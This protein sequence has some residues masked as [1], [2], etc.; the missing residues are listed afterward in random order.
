MLKRIREF[1]D[2]KYSI[3]PEMKKMM[4]EAACLE[5]EIA[6]Q[7]RKLDNLTEWHQKE[8]AKFETKKNKMHITAESKKDSSAHIIATL[9]VSSH[10]SK[11]EADTDIPKPSVVDE[12]TVSISAFSPPVLEAQK[13]VKHAIQSNETQSREVE[14]RFSELDEAQDQL[15]FDQ[16]NLLNQLNIENKNKSAG[17]SNEMVKK[18]S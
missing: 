9:A 18:I 4:E 15:L 1:F 8:R 3:D 12:T 7:N 11:K 14:N 5:D 6:E 16:Q 10:T 2:S 13:K 17:D